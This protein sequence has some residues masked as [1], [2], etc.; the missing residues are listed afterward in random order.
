MTGNP[1]TRV[2]VNHRAVICTSRGREISVLQWNDQEK[3][4]SPGH[5]SSSGVVDQHRVNFTFFVCA[6]I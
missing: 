1:A 5:A 6:F 2:K 4:T 3:S